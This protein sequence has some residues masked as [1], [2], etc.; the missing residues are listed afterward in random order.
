MAR[1]VIAVADPL[2]LKQPAEPLLLRSYVEV[3]IDGPTIEAAIALPR[4][5]VREGS[6]VYVV[7]GE[8]RLQI[9]PFQELRR[10][11]NQVLVQ[12]GLAAG[13][14]VVTSRVPGAVA[15]MKVRLPGEA[16]PAAPP[17]APKAAE[18]SAE[19]RP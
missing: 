5:A 6:T 17:G 9:K 13:E 12:A 16:A 1:I 18:A 15:G 19:S 10:K 11:G 14:R 2:G 8:N 4:D 3:A 7:D